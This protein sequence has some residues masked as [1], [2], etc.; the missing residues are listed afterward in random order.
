MSASEYSQQSKPALTGH[1]RSRARIA[2]DLL[3]GA[4]YDI[5]C[6]AARL[7]EAKC[8]EW[9]AE[10]DELMRACIALRE[11]ITEEVGL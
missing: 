3:V 4:D 7:A 1:N 2:R 8:T 11:K 9:S 10:A 5:G 6:A